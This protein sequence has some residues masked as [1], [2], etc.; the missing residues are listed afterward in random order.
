ML[1]GAVLAVLTVIEQF[2]PLLGTSSATTSIISNVINAL[3]QLMPYIV[4]EVSTVYTSVKNILS[5]LNDQG[6]ITADQQAALDALQ[7][8]VDAAWDNVQSQIDPDNPANKGTPAGD[9]G[10]S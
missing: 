6:D 3:T 9:P 1:S 8:Q 2:L 4:N 10:A 5:L 7:G